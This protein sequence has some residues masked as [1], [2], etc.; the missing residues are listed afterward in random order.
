MCDYITYI[1]SSL[2]LLTELDLTNES[3]PMITSD[4]PPHITS[5]RRGEGYWGGYC[6]K[7]V[8][9]AIMFDF[10]ITLA[11]EKLCGFILIYNWT[12]C[13]KDIMKEVD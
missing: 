8:D 12:Q 9:P 4:R 7:I 13:V 5:P 10:A 3:R 11:C 2:V 6:V 1:K